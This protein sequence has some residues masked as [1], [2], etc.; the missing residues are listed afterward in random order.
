MKNIIFCI[1]YLSILLS[2]KNENASITKGLIASKTSPLAIQYLID[3]LGLKPTLIKNSDIELV[4]FH[5]NRNNGL[6]LDFYY[7]KLSDGFWALTDS[8]SMIPYYLIEVRSGKRNG[9]FAIAT[10]RTF[11]LSEI[12]KY[13]ND[14]RNGEFTSYDF[15][16]ILNGKY[17]YFNDAIV[18]SQFLFYKS[19][20]VS[21][22]RIY[23]KE[24][25]VKIIEYDTSGNIIT[26]NFQFSDSNLTFKYD[27]KK[28]VWREKQMYKSPQYSVMTTYDSAMNVIRQDTSRKR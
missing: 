10:E 18:D 26:E 5:S 17:K 16:G 3:S 27:N 23:G 19:G 13:S 28:L 9:L 11:L 21:Q 4:E 6:H 1:F 2:C 20:A 25:I 14:K 15:R 22:I 7:Q 12:G 24:K 8:V